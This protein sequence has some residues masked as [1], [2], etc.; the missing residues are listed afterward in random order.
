MARKNDAA[1]LPPVDPSRFDR[2]VVF[3]EIGYKP[4]PWQELF[5][6]ANVRNRLLACG[7]RVGKTFCLTAEGTAASIKPSPETMAAGEW[8]GSRGWIVAPTYDLADKLFLPVV[9]NLRRHFP[10]LVTS[11]DKRQRTV[12]TIGD[13]FVQAKSAD[14]VDSLVGEGLDWAVIDEAP[15]I[16]DDAKEEVKQRLITRDGWFAAIGS[17]VP[18][19]WFERDFALGQG[20]G[21]HYEFAGDPLPGMHYAGREVRFVKSETDVHEHYFSM[22]VPTHANHRLSVEVLADWERTMAERIFRQDA[23]AEFMGKDGRV[24]RNFEHLATAERLVSGRAGARYIIGWDVARAKDYSVV[25]VLDRAAR[26]QVFMDRFQGPW[27]VQIDRVI[28]IARHFN[29]PDIVVDATG[30]G[31]PIAEELVRRNNLA[32]AIFSGGLAGVSFDEAST[33]WAQEAARYGAFAGR[34]EPLQI[35]NNTI[36]RDLVETLAVAFDHG[37]IRILPEPIQLQELRLY[38]FKQSDATGVIRYGAPAGYHDDT[39]MALALAW[40]RASRPMGTADFVMM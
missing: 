40:W 12:R 34:V 8:V 9:K 24:Y 22:T 29:R 10:W 6:A 18:C 25:S 13:G 11:Y 33:A 26:E 37:L 15:R 30:K 35:N 2:D 1:P 16:G 32:S 4:D 28:R 14:N 19:K 21:Y 20:L 36:K 5:H 39:V 3:R 31:D 7:T 27:N 38:E 23:L 17:P